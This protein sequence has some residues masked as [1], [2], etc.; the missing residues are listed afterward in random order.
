MGNTLSESML[1]ELAKSPGQWVHF[2]VFMKQDDKDAQVSV[3]NPESTCLGSKIPEE[4]DVALFNSVE[5][6]TAPPKEDANVSDS[7][8]EEA[9]GREEPVA[10]R[11]SDDDVK[12]AI[13]GSGQAPKGATDA[14]KEP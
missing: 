14:A 13:G 5:G 12:K 8:G 3:K 9:D 2:S 6:A 1:G 10:P 11:T 4:I 7:S